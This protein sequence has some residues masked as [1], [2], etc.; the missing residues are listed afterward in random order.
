MPRKAKRERD[1][2]FAQRVELRMSATEKKSFQEAAS[3]QG[4]TLS[5]WIRLA[6]RIVVA[7]H[8]GKVQLVELE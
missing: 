2:K 6:A 7:Q 4:L 8:D 1:S 3:K 5:H